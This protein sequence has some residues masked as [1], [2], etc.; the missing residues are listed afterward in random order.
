MELIEEGNLNV[1]LTHSD[2]MLE[3]GGGGRMLQRVVLKRPKT[4][5][6]LASGA[7]EEALGL[8]RSCCW[9]GEGSG[10]GIPGHTWGT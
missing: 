3:L 1:K 2:W 5:R 7:G 6:E 10:D 9:N 4:E 8:G